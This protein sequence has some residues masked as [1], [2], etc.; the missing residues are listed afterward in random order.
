M[1][2]ILQKLIS[3]T[4]NLLRSVSSY[5]SLPVYN[6]SFTVY[7][8]MSLRVCLCRWIVLWSLDEMH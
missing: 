7:T 4:K 1:L 2:I 8:N 6:I 3:I 5:L